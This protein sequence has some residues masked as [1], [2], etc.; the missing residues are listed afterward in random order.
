MTEEG[1]AQETPVDTVGGAAPADASPPPSGTAADELLKSAHDLFDE[2]VAAKDAGDYQRAV[3]LFLAA[4]DKTSDRAAANV[5][6]WN[7]AMNYARLGD[8]ASCLRW[9]EMFFLQAY[10][11]PQMLAE[12]SKKRGPLWP[13]KLYYAAST[14]R[15]IPPPA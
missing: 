2:A 14:G 1:T 12:A 11:N 13:F 9:L 8:A 15:P 7:L 3:Q 6:D 4:R 10:E 5:I